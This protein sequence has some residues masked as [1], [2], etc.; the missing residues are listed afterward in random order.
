MNEVSKVVLAVLTSVGGISGLLILTIK[1]SVNTIAE[2]LEQK[3]SLKL[4][5]ELEKY[6]SNLDNKIYI[7]K[8]KFDTEFNIYRELSKVF[9]E[10][11]KYKSHHLMALF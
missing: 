6:K 10:M 2:R 9:F 5:K 4:D 3:Y 7:S 11:V 1:I 8:T